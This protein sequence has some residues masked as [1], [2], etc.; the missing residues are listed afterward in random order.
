MKENK[1]KTIFLSSA[2][3][4]GRSLISYA[5]HDLNRSDDFYHSLGVANILSKQYGGN[6]YEVFPKLFIRK[7]I[8]NSFPA[9]YYCCSCK[10]LDSITSINNRIEWF[11]IRF[12][13]IRAIHTSK[14]I[15]QA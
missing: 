8:S 10:P 3:L 4:K 2:F 13:R 5:A 11:T 14:I 12:T 1:A 6:N 7:A 15:L 9:F